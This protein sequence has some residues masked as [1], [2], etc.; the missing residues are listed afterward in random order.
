MLMGD[1]NRVQTFRRYADGLKAAENLFPAESGIDQ[2][3]RVRGPDE[4]CVPGT[5]RREDADAN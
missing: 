4:R 3:T 1:Q 5:A 2:D